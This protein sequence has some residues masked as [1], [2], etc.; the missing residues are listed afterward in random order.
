MEFTSSSVL[1]NSNSKGVEHLGSM[2]AGILAAQILA[3]G[4]DEIHNKIMNFKSNL[5]TKI[6][7]ANEDL[8]SF[9]Y[10]NRIS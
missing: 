4:D 9:K 8:K 5:K 2:N 1:E 7:K 3:C 10:K 6:V